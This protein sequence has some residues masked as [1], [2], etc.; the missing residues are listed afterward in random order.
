MK[1]LED[2][3]NERIFAREHCYTDNIGIM[4][5]PSSQVDFNKHPEFVE[6]FRRWTQED[7]FRGLDLVRVWSMVINVKWALSKC[8]GSIAELGVYR[9]QS[10]ALLALYAEQFRRK[11]YLL[12]TFDGFAAH[13]HEE[14]MGE[15]KKAAFKDATLMDAQRIVG[16]YADSRWI[17]GA[18]PDSV[19][20]EMREDKYAFVSID[21]DIYDPIRAG[22]EFFWPRME[23]GG[24]IFVHDYSSGHW[25]GATRAVDEFCRQHNAGGCL[26][27]DFAGTFAISRTF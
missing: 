24:M 21:C 19:T 17:V 7:T 27:P 3:W 16:N 12:D 5:Q 23:P 6:A 9:G 20:D 11:I 4:L 18:F 22:L 13:Q 26:L 2:I 14:D 15:G 8:S 1:I 10:S 25:P